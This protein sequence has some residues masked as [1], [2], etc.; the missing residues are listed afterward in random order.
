MGLVEAKEEVEPLVEEAILEGYGVVFYGGGLEVYVVG[1]ED[2]TV[3][4]ELEE[5]HA[6]LYYVGK[7]THYN[8]EKCCFSEFDLLVLCVLR[9]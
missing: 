4:V 1:A 6:V 5:A 9:E 3:T 7:G 8:V 2:G